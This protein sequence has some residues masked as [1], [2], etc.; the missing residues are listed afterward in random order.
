[1]ISKTNNKFRIKVRAEVRHWD[2][3]DQFGAQESY[4]VQQRIFF[5]W[6]ITLKSFWDESYADS[7]YNS[8]VKRDELEK[9]INGR[10]ASKILSIVIALLLFSCGVGGERF[11]NKWFVVRDL[12]TNEIRT[13]LL[14]KEQ[15]IGDT[16]LWDDNHKCV[17]L[18][19]EE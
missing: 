10:N 16:I 18:K 14:H 17:I 4:Y 9:E 3:I 6:W 11:S 15:P 13:L 5:F 8:L 7:Y 12:D 19:Q 1:M 2:Y